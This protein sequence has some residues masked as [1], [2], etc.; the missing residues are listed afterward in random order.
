MSPLVNA[1]EDREDLSPSNTD[2]S[3]ATLSNQEDAVQQSGSETERSGGNSSGFDEKTSTSGSSGID[4]SEPESNRPQRQIQQYETS[5]DEDDEDDFTYELEDDEGEGDDDSS[6]HYFGTD[7][8]GEEVGEGYDSDDDDATNYGVAHVGE[9]LY[10]RPVTQA[11]QSSSSNT[12]TNTTQQN[13]LNLAYQ[14]AYSR[15]VDLYW[16]QMTVVQDY[17]K[18]FIF[19]RQPQ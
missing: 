18:F 2:S 1:V 6:E 12:L 5:S 4:T 7:E 3:V 11:S 13:E 19:T 16:N 14:S 17:V 15:W 8:E 10:S 9:V